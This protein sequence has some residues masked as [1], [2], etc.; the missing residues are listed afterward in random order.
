MKV[1]HNTKTRQLSDPEIASEKRNGQWC[2]PRFAGV[3]KAVDQYE[4]TASQVRRHKRILD[5]NEL[6]K[7]LDAAGEAAEQRTTKRRADLYGEVGTLRSLQVDIADSRVCTPMPGSSRAMNLLAQQMACDLRRQCA[8]DE[9]DEEE[10]N[11]LVEAHA[12]DGQSKE[13]KPQKSMDQLKAYAW[14]GWPA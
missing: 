5:H 7:A 11:S 14:G 4:K 12:Q 13:A 9:K 10:F 3:L 8:L 1:E 6:E 2:V